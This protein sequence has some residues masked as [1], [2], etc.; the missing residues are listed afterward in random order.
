MAELA[1]V[2]EHEREDMLSGTAPSSSYEMEEYRKARSQEQK[3]ERLLF[4]R[5]V[6]EIIDRSPDKGFSNPELEVTP[7]SS[8]IA[9]FTF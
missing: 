3:D 8:A 6:D 1:H 4:L 7:L 9:R 2:P 5:L